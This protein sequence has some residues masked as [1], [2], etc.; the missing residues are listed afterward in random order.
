[1]TTKKSNF[2]DNGIRSEKERIVTIYPAARRQILE[3]NLEAASVLEETWDRMDDTH[4]ALEYDIST[5]TDAGSTADI[6][7]NV[8][9]LTLTTDGTGTDKAGLATLAASID[10]ANLPE[11]ECEVTLPSVAGVDH[12]FGLFKDANEYMYLTLDASTSANWY[13]KCYDGTTAASIDTKVAATTAATKLKVAIDSDGNG[14]CWIDDVWIDV[15]A[16]GETILPAVTT[17]PMKLYIVT[18]EEAAA[19]KVS[20]TSFFKLTQVK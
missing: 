10:P 20:K 4:L 13:F 11:V 6:S 5:Y 16:L 19:A 3:Q 9:Y 7:T 8:G 15:K 12:K 14:H 1:M 17:D 18:Q 2:I